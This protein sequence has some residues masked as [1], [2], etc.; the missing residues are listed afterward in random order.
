MIRHKAVVHS[1]TLYDA[2][3]RPRADRALGVPNR[4]RQFH[5]L[6]VGE[7]RLRIAEN[8]GVERIRNLVAKALDAVADFLAFVDSDQKRIQI[9]V[10]EVRGSARNLRQ[11]VGTS[12]D[13]VKRPRT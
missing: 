10:V 11:K 3:R 7:E 12:D 13:L 2:G 5:L 1:E 4:V 6:A 9:Q 8:V